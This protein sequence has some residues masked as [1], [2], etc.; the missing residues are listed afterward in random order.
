MS[1]INAV[2]SMLD[3]KVIKLFKTRYYFRITKINNCL[4]VVIRIFLPSS[5]IF[6]TMVTNATNDYVTDQ[7]INSTDEIDHR[8]QFM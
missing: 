5:N 8:E 3:L 2:K 1:I 7:I 6:P 4:I